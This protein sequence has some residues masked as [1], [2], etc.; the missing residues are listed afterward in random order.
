MEYILLIFTDDIKDPVRTLTRIDPDLL[1][2][3]TAGGFLTV[4]LYT[5]VMRGHSKRLIQRIIFPAEKVK[6][7]EIVDLNAPECPPEYIEMI[8]REELKNGK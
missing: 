6:R 7:L 8:I 4:N 3:V 5:W 1:E 2:T